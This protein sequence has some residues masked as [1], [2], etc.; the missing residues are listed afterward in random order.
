MKN[1]GK[2]IFIIFSF[3][4]T[5]AFAG[6]QAE[7]TPKVVYSGEEATYILT[8][9]GDKVNKPIINSICGSQVT[10]T[11]SQTS[12][13]MVNMDYQKSY[14]LSYNFMPR[15]SCVIPPVSVEVD[16]K[17]EQSNSVKVTVTKPTQDKHANFVLTLEP[18]KD[19]LFVGEPFKLYLT[20]KQRKTAQVVDSKFVAPDFKGFWIKG[21]PQTSR[22]EDSEYVI[23]KA[24]YKLAPQRE[25]NLTISPAQIKIATRMNTRD[26]W[27]T[28]L[29]QVKWRTYYSNQVDIKA[30]PLPNNAKLVGTF[31]IEAKADKTE[32]NPSEPVNVTV[33][34]QGDGNLEDIG[35]FKPYIKGVN[36]FAEKVEVQGNRLTQKLAFVSDKDFTIPAFSIAFYNLKTQRVEKISTNPISVKVTGSAQNEPTKLNIKRDDSQTGNV[37][38]SGDI[39]TQQS[40]SVSYIWLFTAFIL[41]TAFGIALM[42]F[43]PLEFL[44]KE[45]VFNLKDEKL[46][47]IKLLPFRDKD[48]EVKKIVDILESNLYSGK[49]QSI[50]RKVL[51]EIL[52]KYDIS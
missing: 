2:K 37:A 11:S 29:P 30:K 44:K 32:V 47:L 15:K 5:A 39:Q 52:K 38:V 24:V 9:I 6:V 31:T 40:G 48:E 13:Q 10:A 28:F 25:G 41:G 33:E 19:E 18:S 17:V 50:D 20:L 26:S 45:K 1:L 51:K 36:V 34:V 23:T 27:G 43:K 49:K 46:L 4:A 14:I 8:I 21:D 22:S 42:L 3:I 35:S 12:I 7:V 16:G